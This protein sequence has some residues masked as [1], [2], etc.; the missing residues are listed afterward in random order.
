LREDVVVAS[1]PTYLCG[2]DVV[3]PWKYRSD[4]RVRKVEV[5]MQELEHYFTDA[6]LDWAKSVLA[7]PEDNYDRLSM[8]WA[9]KEAVAKARGDGL[10]LDF[11]R[12]ELQLERRE[13]FSEDRGRSALL[14]IDRVPR[15]DWQILLERVH[16]HWVAVARGPPSDVCDSNGA[17]S[18]TLRF[19]PSNVDWMA[20]VKAE[21]PKFN[22]LPVTALIPSDQD[23]HNREL[24]EQTI[25]EESESKEEEKGAAS[26][27]GTLSQLARKGS[28]VFEVNTLQL[29]EEGEPDDHVLF[30]SSKEDPE[31]AETTEAVEEVQEAA[32][33]YLDGSWRVFM[34]NGIATIEVQNGKFEMFAGSYEVCETTHPVSITWPDGTV[35]TLYEYDGTQVVWKTSNTKYQQI[36][37]ERNNPQARNILFQRILERESVRSHGTG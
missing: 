14:S 8:L 3:T 22:Y 2:V 15:D 27:E 29:E 12:L 20:S 10:A 16:E 33:G 4:T 34:S 30:K 23:Y 32:K 6:E 36:F 18:K 26:T 37:W 17:F 31:E 5:E 11:N 1:D 24:I 35:Q 25:A 21:Q 13:G 7:T 28:T 9:C 19:T